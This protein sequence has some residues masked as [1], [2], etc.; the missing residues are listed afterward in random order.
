[1][2]PVNGT[3]AP[4]SRFCSAMAKANS[5]RVQP[6]ARVSGG[7]SRP[8]VWRTPMASIRMSAPHARMVRVDFIATSCRPGGESPSD[9]RSWPAC[10]GRMPGAPLLDAPRHELLLDRFA[11]VAAGRGRA[12]EAAV[13]LG[14][15]VGVLEG[16]GRRLHHELAVALVVARGLEPRRVDALHLH[17]A[18]F[19]GPTARRRSPRSPRAARG[20]VRGSCPRG[21]RAGYACP[22]RPR[23]PS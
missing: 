15:D 13:D 22:R 7:S 18:L 20:R 1:M 3:N 12:H 5:S 10:A 19:N 16:P 8:R 2:A 21:L 11:V 6:L 14:R 9:F 23:F 4:H 17:A